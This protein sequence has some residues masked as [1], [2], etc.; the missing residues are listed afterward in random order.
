VSVRW[1]TP[2]PLWFFYV[3]RERVFLRD[4]HRYMV[5]D[6]ML[7]R[8]V[9]FHSHLLT[10][11]VALQTPRGRVEFGRTYFTPANRPAIATPG[12]RPTPRYSGPSNLGARP[13]YSTAPRYS[14]PSSLGAR[15]SY[16]TAPRYSGPGSLGA[17]PSYSTAPRYSGPSSSAPWSSGSS[18]SASRPAFSPPVSGY[19]APHTASQPTPHF[20]SSDHV[21]GPGW[22]GG[23]GMHTGG[24][25][26]GA[27]MGGGH[28]RR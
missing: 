7:G 25:G 20:S 21:A 19:S 4:L 2:A 24:F 18:F 13:S 8:E 23:G 14:G 12:Y 1:A 5:R 17:R 22:G 27:R 16:S 6:R 3:P 9:A 10:R 28:G 15:P 11:P 26:G